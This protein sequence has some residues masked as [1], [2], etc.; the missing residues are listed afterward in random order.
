MRKGIFKDENGIRTYDIEKIVGK[1][2]SNGW[3]TNFKGRYRVFCGARNTGKSKRFVGYESIM[4]IMSDSRRN[5]IICRQDYTNCRQ[6]VYANITRCISDLGLENFFK[7]K[8]EPLEITYLPTGQKIVFRGLNQP[9]SITSIEFSTGYLTD[10]YIEEAYE[11]PSFEPFEMLDGSLR[12][13]V[14]Y[15]EDGNLLENDIPL[16]ITLLLNPWSENW[17]YHEFFRG[18]LEDDYEYLENHRYDEYRNDEYQGNHGIGLY[19]HKSTY[20]CNEFR[21]KKTVD[22]AA[23]KMKIANPELYKVVY[24]GMWGATGQVTYPE[25][26]EKNLKNIGELL[27]IPICAYSI[28]IDAGFSNGAGKPILAKKNED[29]EA[30]VRSATTMVL[31]GFSVG[32]EK[33]L[34]YDE[35][36]HTNIASRGYLNTD[37]P[38]PMTMPELAGAIVNQIIQWKEKYANN[39]NGRRKSLLMKGNIEAYVD[40][41]DIGFIQT[42]QIKARE[43]GLFNVDFIPSTKSPINGR[44]LF[45]KLMLSYGDLLLEKDNCKNLTREFKNARGSEKGEIRSDEDDHVLT[46]LEYSFCPDRNNFIAWKNN[47]KDQ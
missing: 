41:A 36:Y 18:R 35:Y 45:E 40:N 44:V 4:K 12:A 13:G 2:F 16:Q 15:D 34:V 24:L 26:T 21:D 29:P 30:R 43:Y 31:S 6:S 25:F 32:Y 27:D 33:I 19:L 28:G 42:L 5:V 38:N 9:T 20:T 37:N 14:D 11:V 17:I 1:G 8:Q 3:F 39:L 46:A 7:S 10:V 22:P 47:F 23:E